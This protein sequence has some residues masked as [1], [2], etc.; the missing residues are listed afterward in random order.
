MKGGVDRLKALESRELHLVKLLNS[1]SLQRSALQVFIET[2]KAYV[3]PF[4]RLPLDLIEEI[5]YH[6][7]PVAHNAVMSI[8]EP[9]LVLGRVCRQWRKIAYCAPRLWTSLH[10]VVTISDPPR[11]PRKR[12]MT[13][14][15][16]G[17]WLSRSGALP[18]SISFYH[19]DTKFAYRP[20]SLDD[21]VQ[22]YLSVMTR[23]SERWKSIYFMFR[24]VNWTTILLQFNSKDLPLLEELRIVDHGE[25]EGWNWDVT[26]ADLDAAIAFP[27]DN[28][29]LA[30]PH[31]HSL[32]LPHYIAHVLGRDMRW[33]RLTA[34]DISYQCL[35]VN[36]FTRILSQCSILNRLSITF[37]SLPSTWQHGPWPLSFTNSGTTAPPVTTI[38]TL[39]SLTIL[40]KTIND[41][42]VCDILDRLSAPALVHLR[43]QRRSLDHFNF[44]LGERLTQSFTLFL[45][46]LDHPLEE[47]DVSLD[48]MDERTLTE[49]LSLVRGL[50]R[51]SIAGVPST[52]PC[53]SPSLSTET[54]PFSSSH[55]R[56]LEIFTP[57]IQRQSDIRTISPCL[58][59]EQS[60]A[61]CLCPHLEVFHSTGI[62]FTPRAVAEFLRSRT[63]LHHQNTVAKLR[64]LSIISNLLESVQ[65]FKDLGYRDDV[66]EL[67]KLS[68]EAQIHVIYPKHPRPDYV[69]SSAPVVTA[70]S[71]YAGIPP[72]Y[73]QSQPFVF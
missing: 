57:A 33:E 70:P 4:S 63:L 26:L 34:L 27:R 41:M 29:V 30:A 14:D 7:L 22:P 35:L 40:S 54:L 69:S 46:R 64:K 28:G 31:L 24:A 18:L 16:I 38:S 37:T 36:D 9:P 49:L 52:P 21:Q 17:C 50:K 56:L 51:L 66:I 20:H 71:A 45:A 67:E 73:L 1:L 3:S 47:L 44:Q 5:F 39:Q 32:A 68:H 10:I 62:T 72:V 11:R 12:E 19:D 8:H 42:D 61:S 48:P 2:R 23:H 55:D 53:A 13:L 65:C 43:W 15:A 60:I 58:P 59:T 25:N 6:C